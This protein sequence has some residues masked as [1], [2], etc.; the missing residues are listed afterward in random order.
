M[1]RCVRDE[2]AE[3]EFERKMELKFAGD[4]VIE[5]VIAS[6]HNFI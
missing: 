6:Y 2:D 4:D 3:L 5:R 1:V